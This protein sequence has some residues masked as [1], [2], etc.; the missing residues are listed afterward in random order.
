MAFRLWAIVRKV[1]PSKKF[2]CTPIGSKVAIDHFV[3]YVMLKS[4]GNVVN[5][6]A[7][8]ENV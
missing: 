4:K 8:A 6:A 1:S 2:R 7:C 3:G 5:L